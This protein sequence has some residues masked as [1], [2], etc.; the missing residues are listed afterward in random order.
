MKGD[1][2]AIP[3][4]PGK[5]PATDPFQSGPC[6]G[7]TNSQKEIVAGAQPR[8]TARGRFRLRPREHF[9]PLIN[10]DDFRGFAWSHQ[11]TKRGPQ[12]VINRHVELQYEPAKCGDC[13]QPKKTDP[14]KRQACDVAECEIA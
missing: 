5:K 12:R 3:A 1:S 4:E 11:C 13:C 6:R 8:R 10:N 9:R 14:E 7:E 2:Q